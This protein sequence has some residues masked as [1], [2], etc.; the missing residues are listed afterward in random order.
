MDKFVVNGKVHL[1][2]LIT[3]RATDLWPELAAGIRGLGKL[4]QQ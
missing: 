3:L 1:I 2:I 4:A